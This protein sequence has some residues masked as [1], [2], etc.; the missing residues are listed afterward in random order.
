MF[1]Q[2]LNPE[3][4]SVPPKPPRPMQS[5][6]G[7]TL[8]SEIEANLLFNSWVNH[9]WIC[10]SIRFQQDSLH[11]KM[12]WSSWCESRIVR[13]MRIF[14]VKRPYRLRGPHAAETSSKT[15]RPFWSIQ[16]ALR[17]L[18][19]LP[20]GNQVLPPSYTGA[21]EM[22]NLITSGKI[23]PSCI[24]IIWQNMMQSCIQSWWK[25]RVHRFFFLHDSFLVYH[26]FP[27]FSI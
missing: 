2:A 13:F 7:T 11:H 9:R 15:T 27:P 24:I 3:A 21:G 23:V 22:R 1:V 16:A 25:K 12:F 17:I 10:K 19:D 20:Q 18:H 14:V 5:I 8:A 26:V 6:H 4:P